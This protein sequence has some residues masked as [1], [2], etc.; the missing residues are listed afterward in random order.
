VLGL[1]LS[2]MQRLGSQ[3]IPL[4]ELAARK[5]VLNGGFGRSLETTSGLATLVSNYVVRGVSPE[6]IARYQQSVNAVTPQQAGSAAASVLAPAGATVVIVGDSKLFI[7]RLR[8]ERGE[9]TVIPIGDLDLDRFAL[10]AGR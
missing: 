4:T 10:A 3:P 1:I 5:A 7:D 8:R 9:L 6:E 2:E